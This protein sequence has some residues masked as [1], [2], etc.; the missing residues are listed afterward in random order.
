MTNKLFL[1]AYYTVAYYLPD[2][3]FP[4]GAAFRVMRG[5]L[6]RRFLAKTGAHVNIES[7]VFLADGRHLQIGSGSALGRGTRVY[8]AMIGTGVIVAPD[9]LFLKDNHRYDNLDGPIAGQGNTAVALPVIEDWAWIGE[10]ATILP[11]RRV[12]RGAIVGAGSVV[13]KDVDD[14]SIVGGNP[15]KVIGKRKPGHTGRFP[16]AL[17][18]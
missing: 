14:F 3:N 8:G 18:D 17:V 4:A 9:V 5:T 13:T 6:C 16:P 15:A 7:H 11:G 12:G 1:F 2:S 10:R